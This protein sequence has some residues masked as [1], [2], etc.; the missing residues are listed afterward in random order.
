MLPDRVS[1]P[2]PLTYESG[3][4]PIAPRCPACVVGPPCFPPLVE[5]GTPFL[6]SVLLP[7]KAT[8]FQRRSSLKGQNLLLQEQ[9]LSGVE[10]PTM[11]REMKII[12]AESLLLKVYPIS[13]NLSGSAYML[14][15]IFPFTTIVIY[16]LA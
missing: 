10:R 16:T 15:A 7:W 14:L 5:M 13:L 2:G 8:H 9:I 11:R 1:N 12:M 3:A 4:L 6:R